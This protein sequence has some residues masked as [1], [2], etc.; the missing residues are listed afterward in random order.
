MTL[1]S[2]LTSSDGPLL[3]LSH[4]RWDFVRQRPQHL[5]TRAA[6]QQR[7]FF[8]EEPI[9]TSHDLPYLEHHDFPADGVVA[10]RPR[11]PDTWTEAEQLQGL[12]GLLEA[13]ARTA[14]PEPAV[15]WYYSPLMREIGEAIP[16]RAVVFDCMDELSAF[17]GADP[18]LVTAESRLMSSADVVFTGGRSLYEAR[19]DRHPNVHLLPSSV[20]AAH[21]AQARTQGV[22]EP[23]DQRKLPRPRVGYVGVIDE[24]V[25]LDLV[26]ATAAALPDWA[27]VMVGPVV[28]IDPKSLPKA[29]NLHWLGG[30]KYDEL[31]AYLAGWDVAMMP[32]AMNEATRFISPTK[33]P[34]Y[35]AAGRPVVST[36]VA[37][38]VS[39][40]GDLDAVAIA[41]DADAFAGAIRRQ[42]DLGATDGWLDP[43]D[44]RLRQMS[45]DATFATMRAAL[46]AALAA[47]AR[48]P[49][50]L[51]RP[52]PDVLVV[53]AGYAGAVMAER[54]ARSG[55]TVRVVDRRPHIGGNAYDA[56][57]EAGVLVHPYGPHIFHTKDSHVV[58]YL[59]RF[60]GWRPYEHRVLASV[61]DKKLPIPINR[62]TLNELYDLD[63]RTE[64]EAAEFLAR[65]AA[66]RDVIRTS[67]DVV[68]SQV[69][70]DLYEKFFQ[71]YTR[72]QWGLDPSQLDSSVTSRVPTR[73]STD[74]RYFTDRFQAMPDQGYT[75]MFENILDHPNITVETGCEYADVADMPVHHTVF[76]GPVDEYFGYRLGRLPYRSL[77]F[78]H[79]THD[80]E[81]WQPV[82]VVNYPDPAVPYT[83]V[84]EYKHLT[85][86][87][88]E[89]TSISYEFP[90]AEGDPY[91]PIPRE[92]NKQLYAQYAAL[93]EAEKDV[94]FVGRLATYRYLNMDQ[95]VAQALD[96]F[97]E[98][99][100]TA[101]R[102][103]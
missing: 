53:G 26:A 47:P 82:A 12:R 64:E 35:L 23:T 65:R 25:D 13:F 45:W 79:E 5:M 55:R 37:D 77:Q 73:T 60:T 54:F 103:A 61:G 63:L 97:A 32:F 100:G 57:D 41:A 74:D 71:G 42:R 84:T 8:W 24:R 96:T 20:D 101:T 56:L 6:R 75:A 31:P 49:R 36:P 78:T 94:T 48:T 39:T 46:D 29:P 89:R 87:R 14:L 85:G 62:T 69:G 76:T 7:V 67:E 68:V 93:A 9:P 98:L 19:K 22:A 52:G 21:F 90:S 15:H 27:V 16:A 95:V 43:V 102:T 51:S 50:R 44:E 30:K 40:Y 28:K 80:V 70:Q 66:P 1:P 83:R 38:V 4:L 10:L 2:P 88:H 58:E 33:T 3:C 91:Y 81:W 72:K 59:S 92:E 17:A 11:T 99:E 18:R 86:Q 34:E